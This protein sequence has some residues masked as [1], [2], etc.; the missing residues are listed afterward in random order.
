MIGD[1]Y[2]RTANN[3]IFIASEPVV[4][5]SIFNE[6]MDDLEKNINSDNN[7][8]IKTINNFFL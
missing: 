1:N 3:L 5:K 6:L 7:N 2:K 8:L 4:Q